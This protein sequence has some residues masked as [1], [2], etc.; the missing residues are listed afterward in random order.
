MAPSALAKGVGGKGT[1][2]ETAVCACATLVSC[3]FTWTLSEMTG[4]T[5]V[6]PSAYGNT[7]HFPIPV[8]KPAGVP[9]RTLALGLMATAPRTSAY[10]QLAVPMKQKES[11]SEYSLVLP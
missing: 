5:P 6:F 7:S 8:T 11:C 2:E 4:E 1:A 10:S 9:R 3:G